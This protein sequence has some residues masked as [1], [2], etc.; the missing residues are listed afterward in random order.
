MLSRG[1][2][3]ILASNGF[4]YFF[5]TMEVFF[6]ALLKIFAWLFLAG[7]ILFFLLALGLNKI[8]FLGRYCFLVVQSGSMAPA[9]MTGDVILISSQEQY[10]KNEVVTF[11]GDDGRTVTHRIA[12]IDYRSS[13]GT[14]IV[15]KGDANRSI[16]IAEISPEQIM[17]KVV[18]TIPRFGYIIAFGRSRWGLVLLVLVPAVLVIIDEVKK[19][20]AKSR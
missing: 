16:D 9:I 19:I 7:F 17:G 5:K 20:V 18:L 15:T 11:V 12:E 14:M 6:K 2:E 13:P 3:K 4:C 1:Q 8:N 10:Q